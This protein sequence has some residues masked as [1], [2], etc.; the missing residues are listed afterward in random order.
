MHWA[1]APVVVVVV[2]V[3]A[4]APLD[5]GAAQTTSP[6]ATGPLTVSVR[7]NREVECSA[8][9]ATHIAVRANT[10]WRLTTQGSS[11]VRTLLGD[12]TGATPV[13]IELPAR[14][15]RYSVTMER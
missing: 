4:T 9:D 7:V 10:A 2:L 3:M 13:R 12:P 1:V 6:H 8:V 5:F 15:V 14:T 11:G